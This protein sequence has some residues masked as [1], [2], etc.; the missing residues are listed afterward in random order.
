M[1]CSEVEAALQRHP[2]VAQAAAFGAPHPVMGELVAAAVVLRPGAGSPPAS[3]A[4]ATAAADSSASA[5]AAAAALTEWCRGQLAHYKVPS[6]VH[7]LEALP[8]TGSGKVLKRQLRELLASAVA[9]AKPPA[10]AMAVGG[11][12]SSLA[13][14]GVKAAELA[15][16]AASALG[17]GLR[18]VQLPGSP[19]TQL[20]GLACYAMPLAADELA[21]PLGLQIAAALTAGARGLVLL[22]GAPPTSAQLAE[23]SAVAAAFD[24]PPPRLSVAVIDAAAAR[25]PRRLLHALY[26]ARPAG[27]GPFAGAL[28]P[29][30][31]PFG[32]GL[33][34]VQGLSLDRLASCVAD[35]LGGLVP[36]TQLD[37]SVGPQLDGS[38]CHVVLVPDSVGVIHIDQQVRFQRQR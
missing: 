19:V 28:L 33:P 9:P 4:G 23:L 27:A 36:V 3:A 15:G 34:P 14:A 11:S 6:A 26:T 2:A 1:Y 25:D 17:A 12:G 35:R 37:G 32:P 8:T 18:V 38:M 20:N 16:L 13:V 29:P 22:S 31:T 10:V 5:A 30:V 24:G 21:A 7:V